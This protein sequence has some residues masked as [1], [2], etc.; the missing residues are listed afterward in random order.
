MHCD[1]DGLHESCGYGLRHVRVESIHGHVFGVAFD[2]V[3]HLSTISQVLRPRIRG[4]YF[5]NE[6]QNDGSQPH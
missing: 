6:C 2:G 5:N 1:D 3:Q 4:R